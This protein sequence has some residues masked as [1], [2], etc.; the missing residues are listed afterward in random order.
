M[1][2]K[3]VTF[4]EGAWQ[5][6]TFYAKFD[7]EQKYGWDLTNPVGPPTPPKR[8]YRCKW[9]NIR[10]LDTKKAR[11]RDYAEYMFEIEASK[12]KQAPV[13]QAPVAMPAKKRKHDEE[14]SGE[15]EL[16]SLSA[17][18]AMLMKTARSVAPIA[19]GMQDLTKT[20]GTV[21]AKV[22]NLVTNVCQFQR[23]VN[24]V[25]AKQDDLSAKHHTD[26]CDLQ[27]EVNKNRFAISQL[28]GHMKN[29]GIGADDEDGDY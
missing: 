28:V 21:G 27:D 25:K 3:E 5:P 1:P 23:D 7:T 13:T 8:Q 29:M 19:K 26:A 9:E 14:E 11:V 18:Q 20:V 22:D 24:D 16:M 2:T 15:T 4:K 17:I 12:D 10:S 6:T